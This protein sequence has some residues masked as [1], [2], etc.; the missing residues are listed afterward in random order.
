MNG[1]TLLIIAVVALAAGYLLYGRWLQKTWGI[2]PNALTPAK[3]LEDGEDYAPSDRLSVFA[4]QFSSICGA[5]PVTGPIIACVFGWL[6]A[7]LWILVGGIFFGAVQDFTALYASVHNQGKSMGLLIE[8]H[9]GRYGRRLFLLFCW[10]FTM[11]VVA[12]FTDMV[13]GTF[14]SKAGDAATTYANG[15]TATIN[16]AF[17]VAAIVLG[18]ICARFQ[19][20]G[21]VK[22]LVAM[23]L[24]V[25]SFAVGMV[26]PIETA[27]K[28]TWDI[29]IMVYL[30]FASCVPMTHLKQ[31]RDYLCFIVLVGMIVFA[32]VGVIVY[33][34][35][36]QLSMFNGFTVGEGSGAKMLF[37]VLFVTIACGAVSGFHSLVS[38]GTSSKTISN[39]R[40]ML[41]VGYGSMVLECVVATLALIC[42]A[43][44]ATSAGDYS[45]VGTGTPF[46]VFSTSVASF[47]E[48]LGLPTTFSQVFMTMAVSTLALSSLDAVA[49]IGAMSFQELFLGEKAD[50]SDVN[51]VRRF[52][53]SRWV[54]TLLVLIPGFLLAMGGYNN[55]WAL[56]GSANQLLAAMVLIA[57]SVFLKATGRKGLML[58]V[59][60]CF[61]LVVVF[62]SLVSILAGIVPTIGT[63]NF[64]FLTQG[65][66]L[67]FGVL[68]LVLGVIIAVSCFKK[69]AE[70]TFG[71]EVEAKETPATEGASAAAAQ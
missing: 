36:L 20:R 45:Q 40:D 24:F 49:R 53:G 23:V 68:L 63:E 57:L 51:P 31:P 32:F 34:P 44:V 25:A 60:A 42:V 18:T 5:G 48:A 71:S 13:A 33:N 69:R 58:V 54:A 67:I 38:T 27:S 7:F 35:T 52:L 15:A 43:A 37:P 17:I 55:I 4:H 2:D 14:I 41:P 22:F 19:L 6:P 21:I 12:A 66:Q 10:L 11:L 46:S 1:L 47:M 70:T 3:R 30:F 50:G 59:P 64:S 29:A 26:F 56:F 9:I 62:V 39:E 65:L 8:K 61:M 16:I 28:V